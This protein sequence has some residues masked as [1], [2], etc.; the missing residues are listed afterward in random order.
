M[1]A[2][3]PVL[4]ARA[5]RRIFAA[6][7]AAL[8]LSLTLADTADAARRGGSFGSRGSRTFQSSRPMFGGS[9]AAPITRS[10]S[11]PRPASPASQRPGFNAPG[12]QPQRGGFL[13]R[14][15]GPILGGLALGGL[16]GMLMGHGFGGA[17]GFLGM[18]LQIALVAGAA[19]LVMRL[20]RG[21]G[22]PAG[23]SAFDGAAPSGFGGP[24]QPSASPFGGSSAFSQPTPQPVAPAWGSQSQTQGQGWTPGFSAA[25]APRA[26]ELGLGQPDVD[27][28][29]QV[30]LEVQAAYAAEDYNRVRERTTPEIMSFLAEELGTNA[31]EGRRNEIR[32]I[33]VLSREVTE[34][35]REGDIDY[36]TLGV[37][38]TSLDWM[39]DRA[40][41]QVAAGDP[42]RP[43]ETSEYWTFVRP[44]QAF[45]A[46]PWKVTAIQE[47]APA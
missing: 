29:E 23:A 28:M 21:R 35:W 25:P 38:F 45:G 30:F 8:T 42:A 31:S 20:I 15:G 46:A 7:L 34:A 13:R 39:V 5:R 17:A 41:G 1:S 19:W 44:V 22:R 16:V 32:D 26:D 24:P 4:P 10:M 6:G 40:T 18:L 9:N 2:M 47:T 33:R 14:W 43:I 27:A 3:T 36:A 37:R 11:A 12:V